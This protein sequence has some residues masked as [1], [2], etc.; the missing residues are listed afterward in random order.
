MLRYKAK[1]TGLSLPAYLMRKI[2][3][4]RGDVP[5]S[6][7]LLRLIELAYKEKEKDGG[8]SLNA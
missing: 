4:E 2:D 1:A 6:R 3:A 7:F 5:R 8:L